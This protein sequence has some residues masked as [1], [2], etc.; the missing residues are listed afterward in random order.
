MRFTLRNAV[1]QLKCTGTRVVQRELTCLTS[2]QYAA[3]CR[4]CQREIVWI[5]KR[6]FDA[7][8]V[9]EGYV[10]GEIHFKT[11]PERIKRQ[12]QKECPICLMKTTSIMDIDINKN[13]CKVHRSTEYKPMR[14]MKF[15]AKKKLKKD[16]NNALIKQQHVGMDTFITHD[17]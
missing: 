16:K 6:P 12:Q 3:K 10:P 11:C 7:R 15:E 4:D 14:K 8:L 13:L 5:E 9:N 17:I 1:H 2:F